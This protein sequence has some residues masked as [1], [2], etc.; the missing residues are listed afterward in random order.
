MISGSQVNL[1]WVRSARGR[2]GGGTD[3]IGL[4]AW[5]TRKPSDITKFEAIRCGPSELEVELEL[6]LELELEVEVGL[7]LEIP[8]EFE[9]E[10]SRNSISR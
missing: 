8:V 6:E 2:E 4:L 1:F 10:V 3:G 5:E 9:L 7:E